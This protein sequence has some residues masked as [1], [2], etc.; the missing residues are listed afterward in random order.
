MAAQIEK[1]DKRQP[2][3]S[4]ERRASLGVSPNQGGNST[5]THEENRRGLVPGRKEYSPAVR[6]AQKGEAELPWLPKNQKRNAPSMD[7]AV[8]KGISGIGRGLERG[9]KM[10]PR[11]REKKIIEKK[12]TAWAP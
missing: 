10:R 12:G 4:S 7:L 1:K 5:C 2:C 6:L 3:R 8:A 9:R 11:D